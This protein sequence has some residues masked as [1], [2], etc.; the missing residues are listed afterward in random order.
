MARLPSERYLVQQ[1]GGDVI[2]FEDGTER[3]IV[4]FDPSDGNAVTTALDVI[5]DSELGEEDRTFAWFW[6]GYF[7]AYSD[8]NPEVPRERFIEQ[9]SDDSVGVYAEGTEIVR[10][11]PADQ[12]AAA[13]AQKVIHDSA[14]DLDQQARAH[15]WSGYF[16]AHGSERF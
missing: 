15:F 9:R 3:Q 6:A 5:R 2:L 7:Y 4:R 1:I 10:F 11:S 14:L 12:N 16:Y 13:R 8:R